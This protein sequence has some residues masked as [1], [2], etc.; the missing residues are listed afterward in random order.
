MPAC[1]KCWRDAGAE[2]F[3]SQGDKVAIYHR[4]LD[5]RR[6]TP[7]EQAG[8]DAGQCGSCG[9]RAVHQYV[10]CCMACGAEDG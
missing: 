3:S 6:C 7:E 2:A 5:E 10:G 4:L 1:E 8:E 9:R